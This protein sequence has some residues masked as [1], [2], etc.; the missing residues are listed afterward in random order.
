MFKVNFI[1]TEDHI[2]LARRMCVFWRD[3]AYLGAPAIDEKRPYG[4]S[5]IT[6]DI[7]E[8]IGIE[9]SVDGDGKKYLSEPQKACCLNLHREMEVALQIILATGTFQ[10]GLYSADKYNSLSWKLIEA[11]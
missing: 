2:K 10:P 1:L 4:N 5:S 8:I 7:A 3:N 11:K 9:F 6:T